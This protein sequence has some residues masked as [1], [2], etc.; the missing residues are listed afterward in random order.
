MFIGRYYHKLEAKGRVSFPKEFRKKA[1]NWIITRGLDGGLFVFKK[2]D[3]LKKIEGIS[4]RTFTKKRN[5]DFTRLMV[6]E[7]VEVNADRN[8]RVSL[9][10]YLIETAGLKKNLVVV[11]SYGYVEIWDQEKYHQYLTNLENTAE[12][13]AESID[14]TN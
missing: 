2:E 3:F 10:E 9:P 11:G 4:Q 1:E 14:E 6:N 7:A 12:T 5:R 8:G 13:I